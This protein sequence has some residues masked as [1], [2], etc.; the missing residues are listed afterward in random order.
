MLLGASACKPKPC[1]KFS[2]LTMKDGTATCTCAPEAAT[3]AVWGSTTY[4]T[5]SSICAAAVHAGAVPAAGGPVTE[6]PAEGCTF[7]KGTTANGQTSSAWGAFATSFFFPGHGDGACPTFSADDPCPTKLKEIPGANSMT[8]VSCTCGANAKGSVWG[9]GIYTT[10]SAVCAAAVHAGA[11]PATGGKITLKK[12]PGCASY[13]G[14]AKNGVTSS[15][16]GSYGDSFYFPSAGG[17]GS[18]TTADAAPADATAD[19]GAGTATTT[20]AAAGT[21]VV[22]A[23]PAA[24]RSIPGA[25]S[26]PF[27]CTC[28]SPAGGS[29]W[30]D[31]IYTRDSAICKA[32]VHA[33]ALSAAGKGEVTVLPAAGCDAYK[34]SPKNGVTTSNWGKYGGSFTFKGRPAA[35]AK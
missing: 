35:C 1:G 9:D 33:G 19:A 8:E 32:A 10:D 4:T 29:V 25:G 20:A 31:G 22:A 14:A 7:Y 5:D 23:C 18:C 16:W 11:A 24:Y 15:S 34:G 26:G 28:S 27:T 6:S 2:A 3:G 30:G 12:A 21:K 17:T 13:A